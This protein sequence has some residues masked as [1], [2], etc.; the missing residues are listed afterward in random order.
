MPYVLMLNEYSLISQSLL[1]TLKSPK[2]HSPMHYKEQ[3]NIGHFLC[4][5]EEVTNTN[6]YIRI[7]LQINIHIN[8][9]F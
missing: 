9:I 6:K 2:P 1:S 8:Y 3:H 5:V 4:S 7:S